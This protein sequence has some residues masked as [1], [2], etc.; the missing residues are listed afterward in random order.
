MGRKDKKF[1]LENL[2]AIFLGWVIGQTFVASFYNPVLITSFIAA[3]FLTKFRF[4]RIK[5]GRT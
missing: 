1:K 4:D 2:E 5:E 3:L